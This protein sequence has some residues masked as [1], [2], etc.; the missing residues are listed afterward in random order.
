MKKVILLPFLL[1]TILVYTQPKLIGTLSVSGPK[2]GGTI[3]R[4]DLPGTSPG[5]IYSFDNTAPHMPRGGVTMG[6]DNIWCYGMLNYNGVNSNGALYRIRNDGSGFMILQVLTN[7]PGA[8]MIPYRHTDDN[9]YFSNEFSIKRYD[10]GTNTVADLPLNAGIAVKNLL[11]DTDDWMYFTT[12]INTIAKMKTDGTQWTDLHSFDLMTEGTGGLAGLTEIPGDSLFGVQAF[13]G[14]NNGGTLYSIKK[15]GTGFTV[16]HQF[17]N[18]TGF[19]PESRLMYFD[20]KL[21]GTTAQ[22]GNFNQGVLYTI[23]PDGTGYRV[24]HDFEVGF[25]GGAVPLGNISIAANGRIFGSTSQ[26]FSGPSGQFRLFKVDTSGAAFEYFFNINQRE[27][28]HFNLDILLQDNDETIYLTTAEMGRHD[29]GVLSKIDTLGN[30][31]SLFHFGTAANGFRPNAALI[32]GSDGKLYG[33]TSIGGPDG[34]GT[35]YSVNIDGTGYVRLHQF[36]DAEGYDPKGKLLEASDGKLYGVLQWGGPINSGAIYRIDK[37]GS[38]FQIVYNF[39]N[40][41]NGYSPIGSLIEDN[42]GV[43]YGA[44]NSTLSGYGAAFKINKDGTGYTVLKHF[45]NVAELTYPNDGLRLYGEYLYGVTN[46]SASGKGGVFRVKTDG[47][48]YEVIHEFAGASDGANPYATPILANNGK[49]I[50]TTQFGGNE[51]AGVIY[52]MD[53]TG[54][55]Y[56]I[57]RQFSLTNDVQYPTTGL[58]QG[59]DGVLY[60]TASSNTITIATG[61]TVYSINRDGSNFAVIKSFNF[62]TE[63]QLP[64]GLLDLNG[65]ALPV[66]WLAFDA[67]IK[68]QSVLLTWKTAQEQN[69]DRFE[70]ERSSNGVAF[71][72]IGKV[73]AAGNTQLTTSYSYTD[74]NPLNGTN[75]YRLKQVD[76]DERFSYSKIV[77]V[78]FS[79]LDRITISPNPVPGRLNLQLPANNRY[80]LIRITDASGKLV[81]QK[82]IT[83]ASANISMDVHQLAKGW[84]VLT[85]NGGEAVR[86]VFVKE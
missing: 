55:N 70:I 9:I 72:T 75:Y 17:D 60:G 41:A 28:G 6:A 81:M 1:S 39:P 80:S 48:G 61:A 30:G 7:F 24:L 36:L 15:D 77:S 79:S 21:Y 27:S 57:L 23:N 14:T 67:T 16:H 38:N 84:Y 20:G 10:P 62:D 2:I 50:G 25:S 46:F 74:K 69:S 44:T 19:Q 33:T 56:T 34:N 11:I 54:A 53:V 66:Q 68:A 71:T 3:F 83:P 5:I 52:S 37:T 73:T 47:T 18:A 26:F 58:I 32:K 13:G 29:G 76:A 51:L 4:S 64:A 86:K 45:S 8:L 35:I 31:A 63:G 82:T 59:S 40:L 49:L 12:E 22:G 42:T 78:S 65:A 43:L 85:L